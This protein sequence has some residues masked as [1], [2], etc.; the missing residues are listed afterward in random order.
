MSPR[1]A[2]FNFGGA[3]SQR[4]IRYVEQLESIVEVAWTLAESYTLNKDQT[5][6][7]VNRLCELLSELDPDRWSTLIRGPQK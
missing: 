3:E 7:A 5:Y 6:F 2:D 4:V 1:P